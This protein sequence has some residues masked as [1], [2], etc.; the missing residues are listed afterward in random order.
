MI[1]P[2]KLWLV[3]GKILT[4][5]AK[6]D[7][8]ENGA[9]EIEDSKIQRI[10]PS[11]KDL[12]KRLTGEVIDCGHCL[13]MPGLVNG[14]THLGM[15]LLRGAADDKPLKEWLF[16]HIFP[17]ERKLGSSEFVYT[18]SRLGAAELIRSGVTT[19]NDMYYFEEDAARAISE[20]GLRAICGQTLVEVSG[21]ES[22]DNF[23]TKFDDYLKKISNYPTIYPSIAPHAI[24]SVS[25]DNWKQVVAYAN[26]KKIRIHLHL[27]ET[28]AEQ[29]E[30]RAKMGKGAVEVFEGLKLWEQKVIAAH[31][32]YL[33]PKEIAILG[34]HK[35]GIAHNPESN[36]KLANGI[37]PVGELRKAG[38]RVV[39]GTDG[40]ASNNNLDLLAEGSLAARLQVLKYG[41]GTLKARDA[42]S[43][44]TIEGA[45]ALHLDQ[46]IGSLEVGKKADVITLDLDQPHAV[47]LND[48]YSHLIYSAQSGDVRDV[49][50]DGRVL[51]RNRH[52]TTID[53]TSLH[54]EIKDKW[55]KELSK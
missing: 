10:Y 48:P 14:H 49:V 18:C 28:E 1:K 12:P 4:L 43:L 22:I 17:L 37:C 15:T 8:F 46:E 25:K 42:V 24:Y 3:G 34:K 53:W 6:F 9:I 11:T 54:V 13:V 51:L 45:R 23:F 20:A 55:L 33:D 21:V 19:V 30:T 38:A 26:D 52:Y 40:T 27:A 16:D 36:L 41:V 39:L 31:A 47:P 44:L 32:I 7:A 5:N 2:N 50:V 35:V 29:Q